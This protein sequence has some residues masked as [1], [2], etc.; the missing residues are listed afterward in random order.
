[1]AIEY[2]IILIIFVHWIA[3]FVLQS[4]KMSMNKSKSNYWLLIHVSIYSITWALVGVIFFIFY[5]VALFVAI[6]FICHFITDY[7]T[8]RCTSKLYKQG[9]YHNFFLVIGIDQFIH[10]SQ[11]ILC[12]KFL[13]NGIY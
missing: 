12:Y 8:S 13:I 4:Q 11:L 3:D 1:M 6:T 10:Y 9:K 7:F 2:Q 5:K